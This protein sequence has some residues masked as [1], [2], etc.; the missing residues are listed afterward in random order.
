VNASTGT[1]SHCRSCITVQPQ[2]PTSARPGELL[3]VPLPLVHDALDN[4]QPPPCSTAHHAKHDRIAVPGSMIV[5]RQPALSG[6][7]HDKKNSKRH[8]CNHG[9]NDKHQHLPSGAQQI[10]GCVTYF[11]NDCGTVVVD[12]VLLPEHRRAVAL[13]L[14]V[15]PGHP[16]PTAVAAALSL[17]AVRAVHGGLPIKQLP[18]EK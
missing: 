1:R 5:T 15:H 2:V 14:A 10:I 7:R 18:V 4:D 11:S 6:E 9:K 8:H 16:T 17:S 3:S 13:P 12:G